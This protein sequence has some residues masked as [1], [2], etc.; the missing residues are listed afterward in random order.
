MGGVNHIIR[1]GC[2]KASACSLTCDYFVCIIVLPRSNSTI[3]KSK[4]V[5]KK[6]AFLISCNEPAPDIINKY[7][8]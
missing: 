4:T 2:I 8:V 3:I 7:Y 1:G 6:A 5:Y